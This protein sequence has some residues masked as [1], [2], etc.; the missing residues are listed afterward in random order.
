MVQLKR[1]LLLFLTVVL[2]YSCK[3]TP[4]K[5][6]VRNDFFQRVAVL[7]ETDDF[8]GALALFDALPEAEA[9]LPEV[10]VAKSSILLSAGKVS[11]ARA[12][13]E[14]LI[15]QDAGNIEARYVLSVV[16]SRQKKLRQQRIVLEDIVKESP[17]YVPALND[18][19]RISIE[20]SKNLKKAASYYDAALNADPANEDS[21]IGRARVY[22]LAKKYDEAIGV[23]TKGIQLRPRSASMYNERGRIYRTIGNLDEAMADMNEAV[24]FDPNDYWFSYD[25]ALALLAQN[26]KKE[27]LEEFKRASS[28]DPSIFIAY[29]YTAGISDELGFDDEAIKNYKKIISIKPDYYFGF[30]GLGVQSLKKGDYAQA[31]DSFLQAWG[32]APSEINYA[33]LSAYCR[34]KAAK[35]SKEGRNAIK[36]F[37]NEAIKQVKRDSI[38]YYVLRLY[39]EGAGDSD[40]ALRVEKEPNTIAKFRAVFYL[41]CY[42]DTTGIPTLSQ[43]YAEDFREFNRRDLIEYRINDFLH[44]VSS[45]VASKN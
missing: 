21:I 14:D 42:Y 3:T 37:L 29:V 4:P 35:G 31:A 26:Q 6:A 23:L 5:Q 17:N 10:K 13:V 1:L 12:V 33:L 9:A 32:K 22:K 7:L 44:P 18:L 20:N 40:V 24:K 15:K 8:D 45:G 30:E 16:E 36:P 19:G 38:D 2:F 11:A 28:I 39:A 41:A 43:K 34:L 25:R 27:A